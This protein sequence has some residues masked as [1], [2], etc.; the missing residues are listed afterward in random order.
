M[1][2]TISYFWK[3]P[4]ITKGYRTG[5]SL[6]SHTNHSLEHLSFIGKFGEQFPPLQWLL[7]A[8]GRRAHSYGISMDL[9]GGYWTPPLNPRAAYDLECA[10][11]EAL[12]L[13]GVVSLT[14]HDS[15]EA[16]RKLRIVDAYR[17]IPISFEWTAPYQD[18][19]FH[20]GVHNLPER[21]A[22]EILAAITSYKTEPRPE[23][24]H[25]LLAA[26]NDLDEVLVVLNHPLWNLYHLEP[27][28]F[29]SLLTD[30]LGRYSVFI[31]AFEVNGL[32]TWKEN[33]RVV[34]LAYCWNQLVVSGGDRHGC[35]PNANIN[36][37]DAQSFSEFVREIR[38]RLVSHVLFMPHYADPL[39]SRCL[40]LFLDAIR[41]YPD[42]PRG[43]QN[44]DGRTF[45][46]DASGV[47]SPLSSLWEQPPNF[48]QRL[49]TVTEMFEASRIHRWLQTASRKE[50][51]LQLDLKD[52]DAFL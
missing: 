5:I 49:F 40:R 10:Q 43:A 47:A 32:R 42:M 16:A 4:I 36:I 26:L 28:R 1:P 50:L 48:L 30:L 9:A 46:P 18:G 52:G 17:H 6:H 51:A 19:A 38:V 20:F 7:E 3:S 31:H 45:H 39:A 27:S 41:H 37:S 34:E 33:Q 44:W 25:D 12:D 8:Q 24:L 35:E 11:I 29:R 14:D 15:F 13:E 23:L 2:S 21:C 22:P